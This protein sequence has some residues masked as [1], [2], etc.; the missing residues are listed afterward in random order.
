MASSSWCT[1]MLERLVATAP[2][3][4][5]KLAIKFIAQYVEILIMC[6]DAN[7]RLFRTSP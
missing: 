1:R 6:A 3:S 5:V 2:K 4:V 7:S